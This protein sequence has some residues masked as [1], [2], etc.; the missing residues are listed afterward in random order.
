MNLNI[1]WTCGP[2][3]PSVKKPFSA[4][5]W[6]TQP[7]RASNSQHM[8]ARW[9]PTTQSGLHYLAHTG[10]IKEPDQRAD[11][12]STAELQDS[13]LFVL[14][15]CRPLF[16]FVVFESFLLVAF[17]SFFLSSF[18]QVE[19]Q[20]LKARTVWKLAI[21]EMC[22]QVSLCEC[23]CVCAQ[24]SWLEMKLNMNSSIKQKTE[25]SL[26]STRWHLSDRDRQYHYF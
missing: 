14:S 24:W 13:F 9:L 23:V 22:A 2:Q 8:E 26:M 19:A 25:D 10:I 5:V 3:K 17:P 16:L 21:D 1:T 4:A 12:F 18:D 20:F 6:R 7:V 15:L 11:Y